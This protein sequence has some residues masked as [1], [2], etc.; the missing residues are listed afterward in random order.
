MQI[1]NEIPAMNYS[2]LMMF[3]KFDKLKGMIL[4]GAPLIKEIIRRYWKVKNELHKKIDKPKLKDKQ[5]ANFKKKTNIS[6]KNRKV[7]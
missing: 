2:V 5:S 7:Y 4:R 1:N 3:C 6:E